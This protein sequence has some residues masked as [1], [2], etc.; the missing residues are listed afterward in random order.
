M[1]LETTEDEVDSTIEDEMVEDVSSVD[2]LLVSKEA[3][4]EDIDDSTAGVEEEVPTGSDDDDSTGAEDE[5]LLTADEVSLLEA[6][7]ELTI[8]DSDELLDSDEMCEEVIASDERLLVTAR[9][10]SLDTGGVVL[11]NTD[12][13]ELLDGT[14]ADDE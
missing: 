12:D 10:D 1:E 5:E 4:L 6:T 9:E 11:L 7:D 13:K 3:E 14:V 8:S 2:E